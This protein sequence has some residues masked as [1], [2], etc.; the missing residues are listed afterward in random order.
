MN[1]AAVLFGKSAWK[2]VAKTCHWHF[3]LC[4]TSHPST[5]Q[6]HFVY[7]DIIRQLIPVEP[8]SLQES[9][10]EAFSEAVP[11]DPKSH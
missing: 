7:E 2:H 9:I 10:F 5:Y 6:T 3:C 8:Y 1:P 4:K 11:E